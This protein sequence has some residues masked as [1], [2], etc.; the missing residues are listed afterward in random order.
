MENTQ[1]REEID[2]KFLTLTIPKSILDK[3]EAAQA[4][5]TILLACMTPSCNSSGED[6]YRLPHNLTP[7]FEY[8]KEI[9]PPSYDASS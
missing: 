7:A 3:T 1:T 9:I 2:A 6:G 8:L 4:L 5:A